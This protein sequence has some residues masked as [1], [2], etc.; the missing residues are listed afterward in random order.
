MWATVTR[1]GHA[2]GSG[3]VTYPTHFLG[4]LSRLTR[5]PE[6]IALVTERSFRFRVQRQE[7]DLCGLRTGVRLH[8]VRTGFLRAAWLHRAASLPVVPREPQGRPEQ[9][10]WRL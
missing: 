10:G 6:G 2:N 9:R 1:S 4:L 7:P 3:P 8:R 5:E